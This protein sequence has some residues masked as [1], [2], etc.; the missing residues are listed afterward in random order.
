MRLKPAVFMRLALIF[1]GAIGTIFK[2]HAGFFSFPTVGMPDA[3]FPFLAPSNSFG[4]SL[5][6]LAIG[7][8]SDLVRKITAH[9]QAFGL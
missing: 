8:L 6:V 7:R 9:G 3:G 1:V 5:N 2:I 4:G